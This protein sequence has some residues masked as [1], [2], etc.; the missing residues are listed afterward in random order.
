MVIRDMWQG[1][2]HSVASAKALGLMDPVQVGIRESVADGLAAMTMDDMDRSRL[3]GA[4]G[5]EDMGQHRLAGH[6]VQHLG[7]VGAHAFALAGG[8][9]NDT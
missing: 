1:L 6:R 8:E 9:D 5:L 4:R 2:T 3:E 7:G